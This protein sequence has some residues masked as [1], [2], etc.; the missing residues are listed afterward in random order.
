[1]VEDITVFLRNNGFKATPQRLAVYNALAGTKAH[2]TADALFALLR[3]HFPTMSLAT[4]YKT[5]DVLAELGLIK[6]LNTGEFS[7]RY[8]ADT[9]DHAHVRCEKC[10]RVSDVFSVDAGNIVKEAEA[11][12]GCAISGQQIY[13]FGLCPECA[14]D[15][16]ARPALDERR[17][18]G[19]AAS[20]GWAG[21]GQKASPAAAKSK[22][23]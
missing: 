14:P 19:F 1:M 9:S 10:G 22:N 23:N 4:V 11:E 5:L 7:F 16:S 12:T 17:K 15:K 13:F 20:A 18:I 6:V 3:P 8:D 21:K 2:P